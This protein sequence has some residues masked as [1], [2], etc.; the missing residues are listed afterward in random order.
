MQELMIAL[1]QRPISYYPCYA[2]LM[3]TIPGAIVLS[4]LMYWWSAVGGRKFDKLDSELRTETGITENELRTVK[5]KLKSFDF[6]VITREG[7]PAKTYYQI[8]FDLLADALSQLTSLVN[9]TDLG[10]LNSPN[11]PS[12]IHTSIPEITP[13][14]TPERKPIRAREEFDELENVE[15]EEN[16]LGDNCAFFDKVFACPHEN[17]ALVKLEPILGY[18]PHRHENLWSFL[19]DKGIDDVLKVATYWVAN[20]QPDRWRTSIMFSPKVAYDTLGI[21]SAQDHRIQQDETDI[22]ERAKDALWK[23]GHTRLTTVLID[24]MVERLRRQKK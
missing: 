14:I 20:T 1:N 3:G 10:E 6:I 15:T 21:A 23:A 18:P 19:H 17:E 13:E 8:D 9:F 16:G 11:S 5:R 4:Q 12:E 22:R 2:Q 7:I 24:D